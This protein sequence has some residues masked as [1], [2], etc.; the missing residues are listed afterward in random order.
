[1]AQPSQKRS[2]GALFLLLGFTFLGVGFGA[3]RASGAGA[4][5]WVITVA[6]IVIA[7]WFLGLSGRLLTR[8]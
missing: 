5:R 8:R 4:V 6:A 2:L 3:A 7:L 1:M